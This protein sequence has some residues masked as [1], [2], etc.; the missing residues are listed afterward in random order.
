MLI[1]L[2]LYMVKHYWSFCYHWHIHLMSAIEVKTQTRFMVLFTSRSLLTWEKSL[3]ASPGISPRYICL[4]SIPN[5]LYPL[6]FY[7]HHT[8]TEYA[9]FLQKVDQWRKDMALMWR[10]INICHLLLWFQIPSLSWAE[11]SSL[12]SLRAWGRDRNPAMISPCC[13]CRLGRKLQGTGIW[14]IDHMGEP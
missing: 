7:R 1:S 2:S 8:M 3:D 13:W 14:S 5:Q 12:K 10:D 6:L 9:F 4:S 11:P